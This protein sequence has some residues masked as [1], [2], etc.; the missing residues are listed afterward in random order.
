M[1]GILQFPSWDLIF[2][3]VTLGDSLWFNSWVLLEV[4]YW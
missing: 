3:I 2:L 4:R 1:V